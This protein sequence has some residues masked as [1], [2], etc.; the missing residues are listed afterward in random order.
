MTSASFNLSQAQKLLQEEPLEKVRDYAKRWLE[1]FPDSLEALQFCGMVS[2]RENNP[3]DALEYFKRAILQKPNEISCHINLSNV[4]TN[5]GRIE[6]ALIHLRQALR[7]QPLHAEAYN[8]IGRLLYKQRRFEEA[9]P[10]FEKAL[11][12]DPNYWE[13]HYNLAH[14]L[15]S[16]NQINRAATHY[17]E[18]VRLFPKHSIARFN[19]GLAC[20]DEENY[21]DAEA[22]LS[23]ALELDE[24]NLEAAKQL[25]QAY[26]MLGKTAEAIQTYEKALRL[27][28]DLSEL[29]HNLAILHL[30][31]EE[32]AKALFHFKE[33]LNLDPRND[34]AK[35]MIMALSN[36]QTTAA[37]PPAYL[38]Q[39]FDQY[40]D[41]YDEHL[42][43]KLKY[44]VPY[45]LRSAIGKG[46]GS[47]P[48]AGRVLDIG[49]GTG[50]CG[51]FFRDL[52]LELIGI[53][54]SPKMI[55]KANALDA[56]EKLLIIDLNDYLSQENLTPFDLIVAGDVL[57]YSGDLSLIFKNVAKALVLHGQF[58]FS[59]EYLETG[60]YYLQPTGR[61]A[62]SA[63]YIH[64]LAKENHFSIEIAES[65]V[66]REH[67]GIAVSGQLY[68]L[69]KIE[70]T[71]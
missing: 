43:N 69:K 28:P 42:K 41:Y 17:R 21:V 26:V 67:E 29:H 2:V 51:I 65:I 7:I 55:E 14:S 54:L 47:N 15:A 3:N 53:D 57:V 22:H 13:A 68:V 52:A 39:L 19:L 56:Y 37:A 58:A 20:M 12:I 60:D 18:V 25:G 48:K 36:T 5:L 9:I 70:P 40:A 62:H 35:H 59:T 71:S 1:S 64:Q 16:Q 30:R 27:S 24:N 66:P 31:N 34:T 4:Y 45:L 33:A 32:K 38:T 44:Q 10:N 23:K 49:C 61:F 11:R 50:L 46:L 6:D 63:Q 8:N